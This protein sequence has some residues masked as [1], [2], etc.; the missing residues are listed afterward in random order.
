[1]SDDDL[2][3][4]FRQECLSHQAR[5]AQLLNLRYTPRV[6]LH[7]NPHVANYARNDNGE[8]MIDFDRSRLG[9]YSWDV[10]RFL[11]SLSLRRTEPDEQFLHPSVI[12]SFTQGYLDA[13]ENP[14]KVIPVPSVLGPFESPTRDR[15]MRQYLASNRRWAKKLRAAPVFPSHPTVVALLRLYFEGRNDSDG[16][17]RYEVLEA[18]L[19]DG[20]MGKPHMLAVLA[21]RRDRAADYILLDIKEVYR[22]PDTEFFF[23]PYVHHGLRMV[24]A[25]YLYA[26]GMEEMLSYL[27]WRGTQYWGRK[28]PHFKLKIDGRLDLDPQ[29]DFAFAVAVQLGRAH[30]KS[31]RA[32]PATRLA[33]DFRDTL[34]TLLKIAALLN[35]ELVQRYEER[36]S[37]PA[38]SPYAMAYR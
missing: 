35:D 18:G 12:Q 21:D 1:L 28:V 27:T 26:A 25:S 11:G 36:S 30:R 8:A 9:P 5:F 14:D 10:V 13:F 15:T 20:S 31:L 38:P 4:F 17:H 23:N 32:I 19:A 37:A 33:A 3:L 16:Q 29:R 34:A 6:F 7:G 22:D 2:Y 24:E